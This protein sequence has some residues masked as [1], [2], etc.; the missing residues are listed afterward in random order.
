M[1]R[2]NTLINRGS[3]VTTRHL[4]MLQGPNSRQAP[5]RGV[6][7]TRLTCD[8]WK[9]TQ[10]PLQTEVLFRSAPDPPLTTVLASLWSLPLEEWGRR[11]KRRGGV[12]T[13]RAECPRATATAM[14]PGSHGARRAFS[15]PAAGSGLGRPRRVAH[16][17]EP[18]LKPAPGGKGCFA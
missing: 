10:A 1:R 9:K 5:A 12:V 8:P 16:L 17:R 3:P 14:Q 15:R 2:D 7:Q 6:A 13:R 18:T 11:S 4:H